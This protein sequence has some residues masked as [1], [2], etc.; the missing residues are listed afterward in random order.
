MPIVNPAAPPAKSPARSDRVEMDRLPNFSGVDVRSAIAEGNDLLKEIKSWHKTLEKASVSQPVAECRKLESGGVPIRRTSKRAYLVEATVAR[1]GDLKKKTNSELDLRTDMESLKKEVKHLS[2]K[3]A[4]KSERKHSKKDKEL[5]GDQLKD[6]ET[7]K[8]QVPAAIKNQLISTHSHEPEPL[9]SK[10]SVAMLQ[11]L[12]IKRPLAVQSGPRIVISPKPLLT[13][14]S[15][16]HFAT[17][18]HKPAAAV[19]D[20]EKS[21]P[22]NQ[23]ALKMI[24]LS[25]ENAAVATDAIPVSTTGCQTSPPPRVFNIFA[26]TEEVTVRTRRTMVSVAV[27]SSPEVKAPCS[28][29]EVQTESVHVNTVGTETTSD[30]QPV[31]LKVADEVEERLQTQVGPSGDATSVFMATSHNNDPSEDKTQELFKPSR[32]SLSPI[33]EVP[34]T[35]ISPDIISPLTTPKASLVIPE[36]S[37]SDQSVVSSDAPK[38]EPLEKRPKSVGFSD[39][40]VLLRLRSPSL[41][42]VVPSFTRS[43]LAKRAS[44]FSDLSTDDDDDDATRNNEL[45]TS[46]VQTSSASRSTSPTSTASS[47]EFT[48]SS[49][50]AVGPKA[51]LSIPVYQMNRVRSLAAKVAPKLLE[52]S[53]S[54]GELSEGQIWPLPRVDFKKP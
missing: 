24:H 52:N 6:N 31:T 47:I 46:E 1:R 8:L 5:K 25:K 53:T 38:Q 36:T 4:R 32:I 16:V 15:N 49:S 34:S 42:M 17:Y 14:V 20:N 12:T 13:K 50:A 33:L 3:I 44:A 7:G 26:Q 39:L 35:N 22:H 45:L 30:D 29:L 19:P 40:P 48:T 27:Q 51:P 18:K 9:K 54:D 11:D 41:R 37:Q 28:D 10:L 2:K 43:A 21:L 23:L